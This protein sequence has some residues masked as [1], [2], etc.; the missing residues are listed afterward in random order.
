MKPIIVVAII[1]AAAIPSAAMAGKYV[2]GYTRSDG[3]YVSGYYRSSSNENRW[4]NSS[5]QTMGGTE[6]DEYSAPSA[7]NTSNPSWGT[8]DNDGDGV[9]NAYDLKPNKKS[10]W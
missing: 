6:R 9:I 8:S 4:D 5:S 7:T 2:N 10:E 3:T 1:F